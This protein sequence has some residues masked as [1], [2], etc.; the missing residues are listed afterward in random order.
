VGERQQQ[1][2]RNRAG[3]PSKDPENYHRG[4][5]VRSEW[6]YSET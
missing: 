5:V 6:K 2:R 1:Q 4:S 3:S